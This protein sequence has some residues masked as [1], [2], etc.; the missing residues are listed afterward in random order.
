MK[1]TKMSLVA[2]LVM[3]SSAF[4][5]DNVEMSGN[6][7]VFYHTQDAAKG[8][9]KISAK[10]GTLFDKD[11]SAADASVNLLIK[12]DLA[13]NDLVKVHTKLGY[14]A[15]STLGLENNFVSNVWGASHSATTGTDANYADVLGGAKVEN[16]NYVTEACVGL[17]LQKG[18]KSTVALGRMELDTPLAFTEKWTIE[19]NTFEAAVLINQDVPDTTIVAAYIGNGNGT[20]TFGEGNANTVASLDLA[21]GGVINE[22]GKFTTYGSDGAYAFGV[23]NNSFKPVTAQLWY[24]NVMEVATATWLQADLDASTLGVKG[25]TAGVQYTTIDIETVAGKVLA[26][27]DTT[28]RTEAVKVDASAY[29]VML[30]Y[31]VMDMATV[32]VAYSQTSEDHSVGFNTATAAG[33]AQTKLYTDAWWNYGRVTEADTSAMSL[34]VEGAY[35]GVDLG[36]YT[37]RAEHGDSTAV[38]N[39]GR[40]NK[41]I[42]EGTVTA[43]KSFGPLDVTAA[44]IMTK[45]DNDTTNAIQAYLTLNF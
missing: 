22:N 33:T 28:D 4:A 45:A 42:V 30:G 39:A 5:I 7:N 8:Y 29:A 37:M 43:A 18:T 3:G 2:A 11:S 41:K 44:Y 15:I 14:T 23:V 36:L 13:K 6:A 31:N 12:A 25:L 1:L 10:D 40:A 17:T 35:A 20:E 19:K 9:D 38:V 32:K 27:A 16:V 26:Q 21:Y 24:Y 34:S